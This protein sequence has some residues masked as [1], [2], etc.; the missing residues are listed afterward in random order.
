MDDRAIGGFVD[1]RAEQVILD[2][3]DAT[4]VRCARTLIPGSEVRDL[5]LDLR[6]TVGHVA[7]FDWSVDEPASSPGL[8]NRLVGSH[9]D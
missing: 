3:I 5:L 2:A 1:P 4:I 9:A 7:S 8:L 6:L